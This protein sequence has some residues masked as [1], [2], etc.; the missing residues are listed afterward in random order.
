MIPYSHQSIDASDIKAVV[1]V[2]KSDWLTQGPKIGEFE[3][4]LAEYCG[5]KFTVAFSSGTAALHAAYFVTG[6]KKGDEFITTPLTFAATANAGLYLGASPVFADIDEYGNLDSA[7]AEKKITRKTTA[8]VVVDYAGHPADLDKFKKIAKKHNLILIEDA[9]HAL[10]AK[11]KN[12]KIGSIADLTT[13]SFHPV[14]SITAGEGGAVA[15]NSKIYYEKLKQFRHHGIG[16]QGMKTLGFNY[17]LTDIHAALGISQLKKLDRF[18]NARKK[19]ASRYGEAFRQNKN[20]ILPK[21]HRNASPSWHLYPLRFAGAFA[22][23]PACRQAWRA[24]IF[25]KLRE[26][27]IGAQIHYVPVY[28]HPYYQKLGYKKGLCPEAEEFSASEISIPLFPGLAKKDQEFVIEKI[29][30]LTK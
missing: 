4:A 30:K 10:G 13:F 21:E 7:K 3:K 19:I 12:K 25:A 20:L 22:E 1:A 29:N 23:K 6:L 5:T 16:S 26:A 27:G 28:L 11:Y 15:T 14:K 9:A 17:R 24:E 2:L 8:L 18:I